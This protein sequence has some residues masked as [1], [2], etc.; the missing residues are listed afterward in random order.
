MEQGMIRAWK[1][2]TDVEISVDDLPPYAIAVAESA[3]KNDTIVTGRS[4]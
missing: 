2:A 4:Q 1:P 3:G